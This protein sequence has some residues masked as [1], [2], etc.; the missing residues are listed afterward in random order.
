MTDQELKQYCEA[1]TVPDREIMDAARRRQAELAK[2][3]GSLGKLEDYSIRLAGITGQVRPHVEKCRVLVLAADNGVTAEGISSA[4]TS[5]TLSQ[6]INMTRH[7]TG[8]S[9]LAHYFGNEVVVADMGIDTDRPIPGV[10]DRKVRRSTGNIAREPAMTRQQALHALETGMELA[11]QAAADGVQALGI[12][13]M[14]IGNTSRGGGLTDAAFE[15][16]KQV[17]DRALA[18]H[19]PDPA[20]PVGVLAAVGGLDLAA[21]TGAFLGCA[22]NHVPAVVDGYISIVAA[23]TAVRLCPAAGEYLFLSHASYEIGYRIAAQELGQEPCLLLGMRLGEGSGCPVM[24]Q[25]LRAACA[26][27]DGMATFP[28]AAIE[29]DYLTPI[30][31]QDSFT[32]TP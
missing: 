23:L 8:M 15:K 5:V 26:V 12:G 3:P 17:I 29:D 25:I 7:K 21:M 20:D 22:Q 13:E 10:L 4:P 28:E 9:A 11:A 18:L 24:F 32:V 14:G 16:K 30:R 2:P 6:V 27:M 31:A 19:R 1:V